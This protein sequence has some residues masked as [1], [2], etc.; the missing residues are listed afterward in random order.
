[1]KIYDSKAVKACASPDYNY[2]FNK[3]SGLF[4][5]CGKTKEDD[6]DYSPFGPELADIEIS[7]ICSGITRS[8]GKKKP[9]PFCYK[10]NGPKGKNMSLETFKKVFK[11]INENNQITQ[12][13]FGVGDIDANPDMYR[14]FEYCRERGVVPNVTI[15]GEDLTDTHVEHIVG[16][17]GAVAVSRYTPKGVCYNAVQKLTEGGLKQ[18]NIHMMISQESYDACF[19]LIDDCC[20]DPRLENLNAVV[21]LALKPRGRGTAF[22]PLKDA[23]KYAALIKYAF[24]KRVSIGFD[25]CSGPTFLKACQL[26]VE[27]GDLQ[28]G[29]YDKMK[30]Q[31]E[32]CESSLFSIYVDVHGMTWPCSFLEDRPGYIPVDLTKGYVSFIEEVWNGQIVKSFREKLLNTC[33]GGLCEGCR[34]CPE[35]DIY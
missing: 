4:V 21:F 13:A 6:P 26:L 33:T 17:C 7:T 35:F 9:C 2:Y 3:D 1:M 10:S 22:H 28:Q 14:I 24:E 29:D 23:S 18:C 12:I 30:D 5:R 32:P 25:S 16:L 11:N 8:D 34:Q 31:V 20:S 27:A 15:N 19:D